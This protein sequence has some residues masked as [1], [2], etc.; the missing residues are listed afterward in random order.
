MHTTSVSKSLSDKLNKKSKSTSVFSNFLMISYNSALF[1]ILFP[2]LASSFCY[3]M[4]RES[5]DDFL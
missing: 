2:Y 5:K 4:T 3:I 1:I